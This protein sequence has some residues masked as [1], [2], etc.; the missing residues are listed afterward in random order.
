MIP[1]QLAALRKQLEELSPLVE[2]VKKSRSSRKKLR[3]LLSFLKAHP[4][5]PLYKAALLW[6]KSLP[7][8]SQTVIA[9]L[10]AIGQGERVFQSKDVFTKNPSQLLSLLDHLKRVEKFYDNLGGV[11]GYHYEFLRLMAIKESICDLSSAH[12]YEKPPGIDIS[13]N[14][15]KVRAAVRAGIEHLRKGVE[16]YPV[17]G[18]A[19][20][21]DLRDENTGQPLPAAQLSF[22]GK[23][24][25]E[26]LIRDL[27]AREYLHYKLTEK[28]LKIPIVLMMSPEKNN[29]SHILD[30]L[31]KNR[32]FGRPKSSFFYL[33]QSLV[34]TISKDG[35]WIMKGPL[36]PLLKPG[37]HG[38]L[39]KL[40]CEEKAFQWMRRKKC[41]Y[42]LIRQINNPIAALDFT[43]LALAGIGYL[44]KRAFG[45]V[46]CERQVQACEGMDVL[47]ESRVEEG[48]TYKITNIEYTDFEQYGIQD[49]PEKPGSLFS[50]FPAN[51][52][53]LFADLRTV[54]KVAKE[55]PIPGLLVN[56]RPTCFN[57]CR[58]EKIT[59]EAGRLESTMQNIADYILTHS[60]RRLSQE[61]K[62]HLRTFLIYNKR[63][64]TIAVTKKSLQAGQPLSETPEGAF[65]ALLNAARELLLL[66]HFS[67][68]EMPAER[69]F[70]Q[71]G[72]SFLFSYHPALGPLYSIIKQKIRKG[73]LHHRSE[74]QLEI[75]EL[76]IENLDLKG[77]LLI[78]ADQV[79]GHTN[80]KDSLL[81]SWQTGKCILKNVSIKNSGMSHQPL[82]FFWKNSIKREEALEIHIQGNGEFYAED[83]HFEGSHHITV[84]SGHRMHAHQEGS[85]VKFTLE[86]ISRPT[87]F[88]RYCFSK[89]DSIDLK[90]S[91]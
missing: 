15:I 71:E 70:V 45:F 67:L 48:F 32:W 76:E 40:A 58:G 81:Y 49:I 38:V 21:L 91:S 47:V 24:L 63:H 36:E 2:E 64:K 25:L 78:R 62:N 60:A 31:E 66:C 55:H 6:M 18:A 59:E 61:E 86:K 44:E 54:E 79:V 7:I 56:I 37:G 8:S 68:P 89:D 85:L 27:E 84:P 28:R 12:H 29:E 80:A 34:P 13:Q 74:L 77:S 69:D 30:I 5:S 43:M 42:A 51:T 14:S 52:N 1:N 3:Y 4:T 17:A 73:I 75:A 87:W 72:P 20:R 26:G 65:Y 33:I 83:V 50:C 82:S 88:W 46:S 22:M 57:T 39:W 10:F 9:S 35:H 41:S 90:S 16:I 23:T 19:D 11:V 53:I